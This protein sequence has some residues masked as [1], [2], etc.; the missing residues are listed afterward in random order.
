MP[1]PDHPKSDRA[2]MRDSK[3]RLDQ[4]LP[5]L[6]VRKVHVVMA[7]P[8]VRDQRTKRSGIAMVIDNQEASWTHALRDRGH[9]RLPKLVLCVAEESER[10]RQVKLPDIDVLARQV[11]LQKTRGRTFRSSFGEHRF[12]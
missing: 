4:K 10:C 1:R 11:G 2:G 12:G 3:P 8:K 6:A 7:S 5:E 9:R